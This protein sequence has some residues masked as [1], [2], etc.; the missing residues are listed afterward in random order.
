MKI[1]Y[2]DCFSGIS[3]DMVLGALI[4]SGL[5]IDILRKELA[6]LGLK[7]YRITAKKVMRGGLAGTK[8]DVLLDTKVKSRHS[9]SL[10]EILNLIDNSALEPRVKKLS[11]DIFHN[12]AKAETRVH[13]EPGE[14]L[15]FHEL[16]DIDSII[17]I[18]G[19]AISINKLKIE[20]VY[21]SILPLGRGTVNTR[22]GILPL[23]APA[24]VELLKG[25]PVKLGR[26]TNEL[27]TPTGAGIVTALA[28]HGEVPEMRIESIGYGAGSR[29]SDDVPNMLRVIIGQTCEDYIADSV[30]AL[31]ANI[32]D[33]LPLNY[34]HLFKKLFDA[35]ALDV[36][37]TPIQ[38][39]KSRPAVLLTVLFEEHLI[40]RIT[41]IIFSETTTFG[42]R[43]HREVRKKLNRRIVK[44]KTKYGECRV[45]IGESNGVIKSISPEYEDCK[46]IAER[47]DIPFRKV[48][49]EVKKIWDNKKTNKKLLEK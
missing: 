24:T 10:K 18:I 7:G 13:A 26:E 5:K 31:E 14:N 27:V 28:H 22:G 48:Y 15:H 47:K 40:D 45:K 12:L 19:A 23:P 11:K 41:G 42:V 37:L 2:L 30:T 44:V 32:D 1:L 8:F 43:Y 17:D 35:G 25:F 21:S 16:G 34:E 36:Y 38:M 49:D 39:K 46:D 29:G 6:K 3:G 20:R 9:K 4:D 33:M